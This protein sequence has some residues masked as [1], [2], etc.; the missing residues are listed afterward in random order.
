MR[1]VIFFLPALLTACT[2]TIQQG[3]QFSVDGAHQIRVGSDKASVERALGQ[4]YS[5]SIATNGEELWTYSFST[6]TGG[7]S[8]INY[9]PVVG[10]LAPVETQ[11]TTQAVEVY[12][13]GNTVSRCWLTVSHAGGSVALLGNTNINTNAQTSH[14]DCG[15]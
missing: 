6:S 2:S 9:I 4:N 7:G 1:Y 5:R 15:T 11:S 3:Q 12:F 8:A 14:T 13:K 10:M